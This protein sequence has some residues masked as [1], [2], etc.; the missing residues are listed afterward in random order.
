MST[1]NYL[2]ME[3]NL[4]SS[5]TSSFLFCS[6]FPP[7]SS[8]SLVPLTPVV[9]WICWSQDSMCLWSLRWRRGS[10]Q[11]CGDLQ[12]SEGG[13]WAQLSTHVSHV[14]PKLHQFLYNTRYIGGVLYL[15]LPEEPHNQTPS[16]RSLVMRLALP[17]S[18]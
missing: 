12:T 10:G 17:S 2:L 1:C 15:T 9:S 3:V 11:E 8:S 16:G 7:S 5:L 4:S 14:S 13:C 18:R 6:S